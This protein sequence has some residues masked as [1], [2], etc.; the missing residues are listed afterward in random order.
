MKYLNDRA[1]YFALL[2]SIKT[3]IALGGMVVGFSVFRIMQNWNSLY[4]FV[5]LAIALLSNHFAKR[6]EV[7]EDRLYNDVTTDPKTLVDVRMTKLMMDISTQLAQVL[8]LA[9]IFAYFFRR[10]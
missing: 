7:D 1:K 9:Y 5:L 2:D 3:P 6:F 10:V 8:T 4:I